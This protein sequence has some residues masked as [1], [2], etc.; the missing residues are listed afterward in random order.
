M[1]FRIRTLSSDQKI[2][3]LFSYLLLFALTGIVS[4]QALAQIKI[5]PLGDSIT[6]GSKGSVPGYGGYRDDLA[7][8]LV[9][10]GMNFDFVGTQTDYYSTFPYHEGHPSF[11]VQMILNKVES[12]L[13]TSHPDMVLLHIGTNDINENQSPSYVKMRTSSLLDAI[14][15]FNPNITVILS[16]I[17]PRLDETHN[18]EHERLAPLIRSLVE[19]KKDAGYSVYYCPMYEFFTDYSNWHGWIF[20]DMHPNNDGYNAMARAWYKRITDVLTADGVVRVTVGDVAH[21][22]TE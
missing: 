21:V 3:R 22:R 13:N 10:E 6:H 17:I 18:A 1:L 20:D 4:G 2:R 9:N 14:W 12:Y 16:S 15:T 19:E 5:M 7:D 11:S 8:M